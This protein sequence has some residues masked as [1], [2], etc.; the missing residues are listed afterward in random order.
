MFACVALAGKAVA[1]EITASNTTLTQSIASVAKSSVRAGSAPS[2]APDDGLLA[3]ARSPLAYLEHCAD[4]SSAASSD[5]EN[6]HAKFLDDFVQVPALLW[7]Q[8]CPEC[9]HQRVCAECSVNLPRAHE[10]GNLFQ[11]VHPAHVLKC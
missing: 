9:S 2:E 8:Y 3:F 5:A 7:L 10:E 1:V 6:P 11:L 4:A